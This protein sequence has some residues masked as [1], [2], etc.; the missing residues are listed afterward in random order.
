LIQQVDRDI[1]TRAL[2]SEGEAI[3]VA[4]SGGLDSMVLLHLLHRLGS[5]RG[6]KLAVAH[7]NHQLRGR[8]SDADERLVR[9][10]SHKLG[11]RSIAGRG[12]VKRLS[13]REGLSIEM[14]ARQLRHDFL[15]KA[16]RR[17]GI[18]TI[19]VAH[20]VDDQV[21][22]FF[23]RLLRGAGPSGLAGMKWNNPSPAD[24]RIR[25][26]RPLL[27]CVK[28]EL[29]C[30]ARAE[31]IPFR[32]DA[33]N[34]GLDLLRN[35]IRHELVPLLKHRYQ[36][37]L[38]R[39]TL[40]LMEILGAEAECVVATARAW[41]S[42]RRRSRFSR[43]PVAV[44]RC[45]LHLQLASLRIDRIDFERIE[46]LR[47]AP[48]TRLVVSPSLALARR[49]DGTLHQHR[50]AATGFST[51]RR[52]LDLNGVRGACVFDG[53]KVSWQ[54]QEQPGAR[55]PKTTPRCEYF[56]AQRVGP[57][58]VLRHWCRG[59]RFQPIGMKRPVKLQDW[60]TNRKVPR[61]QRHELLV[62]T[63]GAGEIFWV[64]GQR[65]GERFKLDKGTRRRLKW[66]WTRD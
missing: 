61:A 9:A 32:E 43:L 11:L 65:I 62:A 64:E 37:A 54:V 52:L 42:R 7:F 34:A 19:A 29:E 36:P 66:T 2:F 26:V 10:T 49:A 56:D 35:R 13:Q 24:A 63:T 44:Q 21:E 40:R 22:L 3:L 27:G 18:R 50:I 20:H 45:A 6:W 39:T 38:E 48:G 30:F 4:V 8:S 17:L 41:L 33:T 46:K 47:R 16:A 59:D 23:L 25:L 14:A 5:P 1:T 57:A 60:F 53:A 58:I 31:R 55:R 15:A 51:N 12:Q 28:G